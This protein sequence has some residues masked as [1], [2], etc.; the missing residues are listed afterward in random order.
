METG[1]A[2][3]ARC[4][5]DRGR[6]GGRAAGLLGCR[7]A[8]LALSLAPSGGAGR[9]ASAALRCAARGLSTAPGAPLPPSPLPGLRAAARRAAAEPGH[10]LEQPH[11]LV[12]LVVQ[13][14]RQEE[15]GLLRAARLEAAAR[16]ALAV[17]RHVPQSVRAGL[18]PR[19]G[20]AGRRRPVQPRG[21]RV[22]AQLVDSLHKLALGVVVLLR[23]AGRTARS[24][25]RGP[26]HP[27]LHFIDGDAEAPGG[28]PPRITEGCDALPACPRPPRCGLR[29]CLG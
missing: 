3:K 25:V 16:P 5:C 26:R 1:H 11:H 9:P 12:V 27:P 4:G 6:S 20:P 24:A 13:H 19:P 7:A 29:G 18:A 15:R 2:A 28:A 14:A 21:V 23:G 10:A 22:V 17:H 8:G